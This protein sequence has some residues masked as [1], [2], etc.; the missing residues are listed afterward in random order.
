MNLINN[1][2]TITIENKGDKV[3]K[4][5]LKFYNSIIAY[6]NS[7]SESFDHLISVGSESKLNNVFYNKF[8]K[9]Q[10][11]QIKM[12]YQYLK[13]PKLKKNQYSQLNQVEE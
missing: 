6:L 12:I 7:E 13:M 9:Y 10:I 1:T 3:A 5:Y 8:E 11:R 2:L 4:G